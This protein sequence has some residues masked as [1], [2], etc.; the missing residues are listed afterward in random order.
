M[1]AL[2]IL[3]RPAPVETLESVLDDLTRYGQPTLCVLKERGWWC[4][5]E[6]NVA[7]EGASYKIKSECT[8]ETAVSAALEC[9]SRVK[10]AIAQRGS[11]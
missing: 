5:V 10:R 4:Y 3:R 9:R 8:H 1:S 6:M 11:P 7:V 2:E